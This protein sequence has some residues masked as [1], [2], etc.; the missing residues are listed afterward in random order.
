VEQRATKKMSQQIHFVCRG[1]SGIKIF[2]LQ[3]SFFRAFFALARL[4][5]AEDHRSQ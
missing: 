5:K 2:I 1:S 3:Q 4:Y